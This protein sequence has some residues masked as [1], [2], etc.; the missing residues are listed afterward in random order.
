MERLKPVNNNSQ[1]IGLV[2]QNFCLFVDK[3][4]QSTTQTQRRVKPTWKIELKNP[5]FWLPRKF[6]FTFNSIFCL[7]REKT[8]REKKGGNR[9]LR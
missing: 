5:F 9:D 4:I 6:L 2:K 3:I 7:D 1:W 8:E